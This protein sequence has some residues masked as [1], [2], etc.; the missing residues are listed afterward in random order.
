MPAILSFGLGRLHIGDGDP[1]NAAIEQG[2]RHGS[3]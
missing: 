2:R 1:V 3:G